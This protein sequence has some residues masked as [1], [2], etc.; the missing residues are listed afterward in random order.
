MNSVK[1]ATKRR[2]KHNKR[3]NHRLSLT[4][5]YPPLSTGTNYNLIDKVEHEPNEKVIWKIIRSPDGYFVYDYKLASN[6]R[7][8]RKKCP[9]CQDFLE[10][11]QKKCL[12]CQSKTRKARNG[13]YYQR[14]KAQFKT[15]LP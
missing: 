11:G 12:K 6:R 7:K 3:S 14:L 1:M 15:G 13:R 10:P 5:S 4:V 8:R 2:V 9:S